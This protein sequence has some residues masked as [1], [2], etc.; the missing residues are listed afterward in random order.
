[1]SLTSAWVTG[2]PC[3]KNKTK[4][5]NKKD[6]ERERELGIG[7]TLVTLATWEVEIRRIKV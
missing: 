6:G 2:R 7:L 4:Q 1:M 5:T 3:L